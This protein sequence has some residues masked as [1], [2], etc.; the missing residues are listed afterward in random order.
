MP[1]PILHSYLNLNSYP[2]LKMMILLICLVY[3]LGLGY[4]WW[5]W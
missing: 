5:Q 2:Q 3:E 4:E 1:F